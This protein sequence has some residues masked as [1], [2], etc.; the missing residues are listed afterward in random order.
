[1]SYK[2]KGSGD[3]RDVVD[4]GGKIV[5]H[6]RRH[7]RPAIHVSHRGNSA[8]IRKVVSV[9]WSGRWTTG[10]PVKWNDGRAKTYDTMKEWTSPS[11]WTGT[12]TQA[13][14]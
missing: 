9:F 1:M 3:F 8:T 10:A 13:P 4:D 2:I 7:E 12:N 14:A 11:A 5:G 6:I